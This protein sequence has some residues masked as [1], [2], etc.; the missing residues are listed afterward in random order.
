MPIVLD[1][2]RLLLFLLTILAI[3][4]YAACIFAAKRF[5]SKP[6]PER[7]CPLLPVTI[8]IP[9]CG[10]DFEALENH[11]SF[12][13]Q[14][15]PT[16]QIVF[17]ARDPEDP[18]IPVVRELMAEFPQRDIQLVIDSASIGRN[19]KVD[20]LQNMLSRAKHEWI[21]LADSDI[22]VGSDYL[23]SIVAPLC[24]RR[25]GLVTCLYRAGKAPNTA[26]KLEAVGITG[27]FAP[28][29]LM[30]WL[31]EGV[32]F[33]LGASVAMTKEKLRAIGG[34]KAVADYLADD[35]ML[36]SLM[37]KAGYEVLLSPYIVE[38]L[39]P[40]ASFTDMV[41]HQIRWS[42][43]IRACRPMGHLGS[44][45]THGTALALLNT[46]AQ[47]ASISSLL[48]LASVL[49]IRCAMAWLVGVRLLGDGLLR[50]SLWLLPVRDILSFFVW[51]VSLFGKKVVWRDKVFTIVGN[52]KIV[53]R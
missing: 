2:V 6:Q 22:R 41:K 44:L 29:V 8:L 49:T 34:F 53:P 31:T 39:P 46:I 25:V 48:L 9:L 5:F 32:S 40:P 38:T 28:G 43:G 11:A 27:E 20:N 33:A 14:D 35:Y 26:S 36:G 45:V 50:Q 7:G 4:Y 19:P 1:I 24:D 51:C 18:S 17:G 42:R 47:G 37:R 12:C 13:R 15:Y 10:T 3:L 16:Y 21:V 23:A 52:G 30:A